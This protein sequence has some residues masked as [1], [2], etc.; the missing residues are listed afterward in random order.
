M[1]SMNVIEIKEPGG[2]DVLCLA[3]RPVPVPGRDEVLIK[4]HAAGVN[5]P[6]LLQRRGQYAPP[7]GAS[8]ILG[9]E[10]AGEITA[11]G[12]D[13]ENF[14]VGDRVCALISG[15]GYAEY[16]VAPVEQVLPVPK[17]MDFI[18]AAAL[19]ECVFTVWA[20]VFELGALRKGETLLVHGGG[21]GI[22]HFAIQM[23]KAAGATVI[24]TAGSDEKVQKCL[25]LGADVAINHKTQN[26]ADVI[27][28]NKVDVVLDM[29][30]KDY[31]DRHVDCLDMDGRLVQIAFLSGAQVDLDFRKIMAKRLRITGSFLR[32]RPGVEKA[33]LA[34]EVYRHV[35]GWI[36]SGRVQPVIDQVFS[37]DQ[38]GNAHKYMELSQHFGKIVLK[39]T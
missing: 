17:G 3:Q 16:C 29:V 33:R 35:W 23:A 2:S 7:P 15:G 21:G 18:S 6:D 14:G 4:I 20:N 5:Y 10:V 32:S 28:A 25:D 9:L 39:I 27:G 31:F 24:T 19:P 34:G 22:G 11:C 26:F 13:V 30:G 8:D 1:H 36:E 37:L 12:T 38:A